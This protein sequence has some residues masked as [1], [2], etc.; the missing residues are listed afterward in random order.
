[1]AVYY[2]DKAAPGTTIANLEVGGQT[3]QQLETSVKTLIGNL[4]L[5]LTYNGKSV[6]AS[7]DDLGVSVDIKKYADEALATGKGNPFVIAFTRPH[8]DLKGSYDRDK[9]KTFLNNNF[10]ELSTNPVDAQVVYDNSQNRYFV[11]PGA[12]GHSIDLDDLYKEI[13]NLLANPKLANY[14]IKID[15]QNPVVSNA[16]AQAVADRVNNSLSQVIQIVNNGR[17]LWTLDP[18]DIAA[19]TSFSIDQN[20]GSYAINYD[21]EKI[22]GF[23]NDAVVAQLAGKPV[24]QRAITDSNGNILQVVSPGQNGQLPNNID[25]VVDQ[26]YSHL[27]DGQ[28][29]QIAL[30]T[31]EAAYGTDAK[32]AADGHW[33]EYNL[34]TYEV[35][36]WDGKN[37]AWSTDQTS[38]GKPSTPT[39]T[40]LYSVWKKTYEQ[41]MPNPPSTV[42]LCNIHYVTYWEASGYA[43]HEA[44]WMSYA[45]GNVRTGLS[46]GCIN[47]FIDDAKRVYDWSSIG[48]PVWV[49]Y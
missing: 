11:Q 23:V 36:L 39:I 33:I 26:V 6:T 38:K 9:I 12:P 13:D 48:T 37:I 24:N 16:A 31:T 32:I 21:K 17:I 14:E 42:P 3:K 43:F 30:T 8:F 5:S 2:R 47:M 15:E 20:A 40:G 28:G 19:W 22:K 46:H 41:C 4:R 44:W 18:W 10:P 29:G 45:K 7:A 35:R 25:D 1:M 34:S 49:H 27:I